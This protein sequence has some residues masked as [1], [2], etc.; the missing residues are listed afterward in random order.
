M[1]RWRRG[2]GGGG[3]E[4]RPSTEEVHAAAQLANAHDF[5]SGFEL[6]YA[7]P[8]GERGA[9]L[10]GGQKQRIAIARAVVRKPAILLLDEATSALD[11]TSERVVQAAIDEIMQKQRRTTV[12]I[13]HRLSTIR[14]ADKIA[15]VDR[16]VVVEQGRHEELMSL[17][18][19]Y[20][21]LIAAQNT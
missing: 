18:G 1:A 8:V 4:G 7:T 17:K 2:G 15:V 21:G 5:V 9:Q 3:G 6:G 11:T 16:G 13:A 12:T 19:V 14:H 10:S 20:A